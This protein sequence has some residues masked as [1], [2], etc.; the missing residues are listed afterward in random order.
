LNT[1]KKNT[2][3][4][5]N[6]KAKE[7]AHSKDKLDMESLYNRFL[8]NIPSGGNILDLGCGTGRDAAAFLSKG[9]NVTAVDASEGMLKVAAEKV[10][11][12]CLVNCSFDEISFSNSF[13]GVWA[14]ASLLHVPDRDLLNTIKKIISTLNPGGVFYCSFKEG[15]DEGWQGDRFFNNQTIDSLKDKLSQVENLSISDIWQSSVIIEEVKVN[16]INAL[17]TRI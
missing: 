15:A 9:Y 3:N 5:Y 6:S 2:L 11:E 4:Y 10:P 14:C 7:F 16:W 1:T 13:D 8:K 12:T 17:G